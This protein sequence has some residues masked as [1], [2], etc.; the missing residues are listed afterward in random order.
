MEYV[1]QNMCE[2]V[3]IYILFND[4]YYVNLVSSYV[5]ITLIYNDGLTGGSGTPPWFNVRR[6]RRPV[7]S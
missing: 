1:L 3:L 6:E 2:T 7:L 5:K 4:G